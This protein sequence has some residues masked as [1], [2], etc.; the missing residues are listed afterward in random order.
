GMDRKQFHHSRMLIHY[1]DDLADGT[2]SLHCAAI[3]LSINIDRE[4]KAIWVGDNASPAE[5]KPLVDVDKARFLVGSSLK[6]VMTKRSKV[7]YGTADAAAA[8][9]A[10]HGGELANF[11]QALLAAYTDMSQDVSMIR[12][13][14]AE[15]RKRMLEQQGKS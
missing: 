15:R 8:S 6:G 12:K 14:R 4:P 13:N 7:A 11:D 3:S 2:C 10:A 5:L 9:R 1:G